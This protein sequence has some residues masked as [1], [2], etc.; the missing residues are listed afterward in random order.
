MKYITKLLLVVASTALFAGVNAK[1]LSC[2][3]PDTP[4]GSCTIKWWIPGPDKKPFPGT[5]EHAEVT[6]NAGGTCTLGMIPEQAS[7]FTSITN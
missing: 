6:C 5:G 2:S 3:A 4:R 1:E 7:T